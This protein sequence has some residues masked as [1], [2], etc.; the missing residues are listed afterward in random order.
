MIMDKKE[1]LEYFQTQMVSKFDVRTIGQLWRII[2]EDL[3]PGIYEFGKSS[4]DDII[5]RLKSDEPIQYITGISWFMDLKISVNPSVLIPRP[6][7]EEL[8]DYTI[9]KLQDISPL[10]GEGV[11]NKNTNI[12]DIGTG[13][14]CIPLAIKKNL[15]GSEVFGLDISADALQVARHNGQNLGLNVNWIQGDILAENVLSPELMFDAIIS[16]PPYIT[17]EERK[18]MEA[19]VLKYEPDVALFIGNDDPLQFYKAIIPFAKKYLSQHGFIALECNENFSKEVA[20]LYKQKIGQ[21]DIITDMQGKDR[22]VFSA[23]PI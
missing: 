17:I 7:T 5:K 14:G 8:V 16:N 4:L 10:R 21:S 18:I 13:S 20:K 2:I 11:E 3:Y 1:A 15:P 12:L 9:K 22:F 6:E 19:S 23:F